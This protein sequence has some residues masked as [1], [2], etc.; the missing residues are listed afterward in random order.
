MLFCLLADSYADVWLLR[1]TGGPS[2]RLSCGGRHTPSSLS[3]TWGSHRRRRLRGA[4]LSR[5][6]ASAVRRRTPEIFCYARQSFGDSATPLGSDTTA[7][8]S[9][10]GCASR[11]AAVSVNRLWSAAELSVGEQEK[12]A[13]QRPAAYVHCQM[14]V[15]HY[16]CHVKIGCISGKN[17]E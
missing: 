6:G 16:A 17:Y 15:S 12:K 3:L 11:S 8:R 13:C 10:C 1:Y 4:H 9:P 14:N 2:A 7:C 5:Y